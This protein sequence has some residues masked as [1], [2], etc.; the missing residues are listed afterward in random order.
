MGKIYAE[1]QD[2]H[3][4]AVEPEPHEYITIG[5][6]IGYSGSNSSVLFGLTRKGK[7]HIFDQIYKPGHRHDELGRLIEERVEFWRVP[8]KNYTIFTDVDK[9]LMAELQ[10]RGLKVTWADKVDPFACRLALKTAFFED[11]LYVDPRRCPELVA[12]MNSA[13]WSE[14]IPD[15]ME[16]TGDPNGGHWDSEASLRYFFRGAMI[17]LEK[18]EETP[19]HV[20]EDPGAHLEWQ[21]REQRRKVAKEDKGP[22]TFEY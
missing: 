2:R 22:I 11:K 19:A 4:R 21:L 5:V 10:S 6:D 17:E 3:N 9:D 20:Q 8:K 1:Y 15:E 13:V 16:M 18:P 14:K 7:R 12:E